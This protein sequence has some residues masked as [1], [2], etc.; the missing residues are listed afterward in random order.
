MRVAILGAKGYVGS[1]LL[2]SFSKLKDIEVIGVTVENY[3][4]AKKSSYD[5]IVNAAMPSGRFWAKQNPDKDFLETVKKTAD[6][7]YGWKF[8]KLI[9]ISSISARSQLD[10]VYGRHKAAAEKIVDFGDNL[11]VRLGPMYSPALSKGVL[12]DILKG[13]KVFVDRKSRYCFTPV[14]TTTDWIATN[15][16]KSGLVEVGARNA[17]SLEKVAE[18]LGMKIEFEGSIDHQEV[19]NPPPE[20]PE[21]QEVFSFLDS[22]RNTVKNN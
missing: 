10:I 20:F 22:K 9:Q 4:E 21:A 15:A 7:V 13:E 3:E 2:A 11:V 5:I 6:F 18:Y 1:E 19:L 14:S 16:S 17:I 8:G 12:I